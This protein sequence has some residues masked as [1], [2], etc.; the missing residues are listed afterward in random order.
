MRWHA[1]RGPT[2][3]ALAFAVVFMVMGFMTLGATGAFFGMAAAPIVE[4][5]RGMAP[6]SLF[7]GDQA[8]GRALFLAI[9]TPASIPLFLLAG[10]LL[11]RASIW[12]ALLVMFGGMWL[13]TTAALLWISYQ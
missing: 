10:L 5:I 12:P 4:M 6:G 11:F 13:W 7:V 1:V 3:I 9:V 2:Y 8:F